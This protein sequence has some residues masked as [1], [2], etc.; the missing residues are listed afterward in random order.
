MNPNSLS[1]LT[2]LITRPS[3]QVESMRRAIESEGA[4]VL[5]LP[6]IEIKSSE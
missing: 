6:L 3:N 1:G 4:K 2:V 5:S